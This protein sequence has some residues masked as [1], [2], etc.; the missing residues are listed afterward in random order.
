MVVDRFGILIMPGHVEGH[1]E[2]GPCFTNFIV[3]ESR[4]FGVSDLRDSIVV[5]A[6]LAILSKT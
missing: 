4:P 2:E 5:S 3:P 1:T 6:L